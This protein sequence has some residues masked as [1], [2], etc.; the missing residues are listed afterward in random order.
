MY[1]TLLHCSIFIIIIAILSS[2]YILFYFNNQSNTIIVEPS[3]YTIILENV[4]S[5]IDKYVGKKILVSGYVYVQEDFSQ[6]RFVIAQN[7]YINSTTDNEPF[8]VGFLCENKSKI[9]ISPNEIIK[10][11][12]ILDKCIYNN[13]EY[14]IILVNKII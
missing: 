13:L 5:N 7:V 2:I 10:I 6:N 8:V 1:K 11:E 9:N 12:G 4:H 3:E 14:P